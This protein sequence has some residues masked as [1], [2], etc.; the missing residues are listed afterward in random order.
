M[1]LQTGGGQRGIG[2]KVQFAGEENEDDIVGG[3]C[4]G[5]HDHLDKS[6]Q[7]GANLPT[8]KFSPCALLQ[9][10]NCLCHCP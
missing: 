5:I 9:R 10:L 3:V 4:E 1:E 7:K 2:S 8:M 6:L